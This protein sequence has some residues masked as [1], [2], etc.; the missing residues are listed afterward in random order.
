MAQTRR[1]RVALVGCGQIAD[2]HLQQIRLMRNAEIV[3]VCDLEPLLARQA[4]ERFQV[5]GQFISVEQMLKTARPD[6]VHITTPVQSHA[7]LAVE[8]LSAGV[9]VYVEKPFTLN[10]ADAERVV[11]VAEA[12]QRLICGGHDQLCD[13]VWL[14]CRR[15]VQSGALGDVQH[16]DSILCYPIDGPFGA[17]VVRDPQHWVRRLPGG[18]FH[19]TMSHPLYRIT[20][21]LDD[22]S[23]EIW[24]TWFNRLPNIPVPTE[25]RV[26]LKGKQT[27]GSLLFMSTTKPLHRLVRIYGTKGSI[28]VDVNSQIIRHDGLHKLPGA[29]GRLEAPLNHWREAYR[30]TRRQLA[31]FWKG[32]LHYFSGMRELFRQFYQAILEGT[33]SPIPNSEIIRVTDIMDRIFENCRV[34]ELRAELNGRMETRT[35]EDTLRLLERAS[36][37]LRSSDNVESEMN[38]NL[39]V[40]LG[41][42]SQSSRRDEHVT[43]GS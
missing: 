20:D 41:R 24:A 17:T 34:Q 7:N 16:V 12:N 42:E 22:A 37:L 26:H 32:E 18:L 5:P 33:P 9:H 1:L 25:M 36:A 8:L 15:L 39:R 40:S 11:Q 3:A 21:F 2:A 13:P 19:N 29:L 30:N 28:E 35:E 43:V 14:D 31:R 6:V 38:N 4:A 27:T 10:L 23:P